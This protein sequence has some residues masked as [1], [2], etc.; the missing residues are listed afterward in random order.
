MDEKEGFPLITFLIATVYLAVFLFTYKNINFYESN[1][2][3]VPANIEVPSIFTYSVIHADVFHLLTNMALLIIIGILLE[4]SIGKF[5]FL[6]VY[7]IS[8]FVAILFDI[9]GRILLNIPFSLPF[10]G[11]SGAIF[12][13]LGVAT[14]FKPM[15]KIST[16]FLLVSLLPFVRLVPESGFFSNALYVTF[17]M[18]AVAAAML[19]F[20]TRALRLPLYIV[21]I[22]YLFT[23][24]ISLAFRYPLSVSFIGHI[25]GLAGGI[26]GFILMAKKEEKK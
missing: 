3:F 15:E 20:F 5:Y 24:L 1:F 9:L 11:G 13:L 21:T 18:L 17:G 4:D 6:F 19:F 23:W 16:L 22:T 2:G 7:L 12:G 26:I 10:I 8:S 14:L 25:G